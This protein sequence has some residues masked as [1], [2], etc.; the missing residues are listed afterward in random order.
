MSAPPDNSSSRS[1]SSRIES[2][3]LGFFATVRSCINDPPQLMA[4]VLQDALDGAFRTACFGSNF[5]DLATFDAANNHLSLHIGKVAHHFLDDHLE[6]CE[7]QFVGI[8]ASEL[9]EQVGIWGHGRA[10]VA[11]LSAMVNRQTSDLVER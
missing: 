5:F 1:N 10:N 7:R 2:R 4:K 8:A 9:R 3:S 6:R 11:L